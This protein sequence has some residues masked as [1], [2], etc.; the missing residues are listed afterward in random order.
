MGL[1]RFFSFKLSPPLTAATEL[2]NH[3]LNMARIWLFTRF[4]F[5]ILKPLINRKFTSGEFVLRVGYFM[6][7]TK[8]PGRAHYAM[9]HPYQRGTEFYFKLPHRLHHRLPKNY[10]ITTEK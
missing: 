10:L 9:K 5:Y 4:T 7:K 6:P 3:V 1:E 2:A 8:G